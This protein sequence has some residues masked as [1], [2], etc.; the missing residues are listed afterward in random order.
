MTSRTEKPLATSSSRFVSSSFLTLFR[1][2]KTSDQ[3]KRHTF[4]LALSSLMSARIIS[5]ST[6]GQRPRAIN[7][8]NGESFQQDVLLTY[9]SE[10]EEGTSSNPDW[11]YCAVYIDHIE[12]ERHVQ[13]SRRRLPAYDWESIVFTDHR[14]TEDD[15]HNVICIGVCHEDGS[16]H[17]SWDLH[18]SQFNYR[19]SLVDLVSDPEH[20]PWTIEAFGPVGHNLPGLDQDMSEVGSRQSRSLTDRQ[21]TLDS[22]RYP[23]SWEGPCCWISGRAS[24]GSAMSGCS[25]IRKGVGAV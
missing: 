3:D 5:S 4:G 10:S 9:N 15:G 22:C 1:P 20:A 24:R 11:Q 19:R 6:L 13:L 7:N 12:G 16:L 18:S 8:L 25:C 14:Q 2:S 21:H 17:M 23:S